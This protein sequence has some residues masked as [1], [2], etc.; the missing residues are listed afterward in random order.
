MG[1]LRKLAP[2]AVFVSIW[3]ERISGMRQRS[4]FD[5]S[6]ASDKDRI[7][8]TDHPS[9]ARLN[10]RTFRMAPRLSLPQRPVIVESTLADP[11][12]DQPADAPASKRTRHTKALL[13]EP[14]PSP[15][16]LTK[17]LNIQES[18]SPDDLQLIPS[19]LPP[20]SRKRW[21]GRY[22]PSPR[23]NLIKLSL[24]SAVLFAV[25]A[26]TIASAGGNVVSLLFSAFHNA[27]PYAPVAPTP[28]LVTLRVHAIIQADK[29]AGYDSPAQHD[30][31][32]N[33]AC[34][35]AAFTEVLHAW[36]VT[37]VTLGEIIDEMSAHNPPYITP[38]GGLMSQNA[39]GYIAQIHHFKATVQYNQSLSY[40]DI[41]RLTMNQGIPVIIG[42]ADYSGTYPAFSVGHFLV[43]VGGQS[44]GMNIVDSSLY[45][46]TFLPHDEFLSLWS[47]GRGETIVLTP[48]NS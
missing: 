36:G 13:E 3:Y 48:A 42:V 37:S 34:S 7:S 35:A 2:Y 27:V 10:S 30:L 9:Q 16:A 21:L 31:Y 45:K 12:E 41:V 15:T 1:R 43:V 4:A 32:W 26:A 19:A 33:A 47:A 8:S 5:P 6:D 17:P 14:A 20:R 28:G 39:W 44:G 40:D 23:L 22:S 24:V 25:L 46:I 11:L 38:W 29:D 18:P